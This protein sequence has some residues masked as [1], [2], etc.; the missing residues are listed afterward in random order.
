MNAL[1]VITGGNNV[2]FLSLRICSEAPDFTI[3]V[4]IH[5]FSQVRIT[6]SHLDASVTSSDNKLAIHHIDSANK[7]ANYPA[8]STLMRSYA[9]L[10]DVAILGA[11]KE[12][13]F[14]ESKSAN[15]A[16]V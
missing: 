8:I 5:N 11:R 4:R 7:I 10:M 3:T 2:F 1:V 6:V 16:L 9:N 12:F 15:E 14:G 13:A